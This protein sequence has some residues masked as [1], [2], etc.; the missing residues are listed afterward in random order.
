MT[1][2]KRGDR[3][4]S[5][6]DGL[7]YEVVEFGTRDDLAPLK[8]V[9]QIGY[10]VVVKDSKGLT[11]LLYEWEIEGFEALAGISN[12]DGPHETK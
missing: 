10:C 1:Q 5:L 9:K 6:N 8:G 2:Y 12:E 7:E 3:I 4:I 11:H